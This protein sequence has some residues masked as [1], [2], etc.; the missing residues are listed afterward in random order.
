MYEIIKG[1]C[2]IFLGYF[3]KIVGGIFILVKIIYISFD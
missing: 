1:L 3:K 2:R